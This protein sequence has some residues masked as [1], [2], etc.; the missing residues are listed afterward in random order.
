MLFFDTIKDLLE[1][2]RGHDFYVRITDPKDR[3][4]GLM[5]MTRWDYLS[6]DLDKASDTVFNNIRTGYIHNYGV[7]I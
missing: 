2:L 3:S 7:E 6:D 1:R 4:K 5:W